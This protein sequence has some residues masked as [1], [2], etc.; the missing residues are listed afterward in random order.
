[1]NENM[2]T[3]MVSII[4]PVYKVPEQYLRQCIESCINQTMRK[5]EIILV[6]DGSPDDCGKI[7]DEYAKKDE[8]VRV[9]HKENGG[10][11]SARNAGFEAIQG[12]WHMYI[13]GDDWIDLDTCE[14]IFKVLNKY[15]DIDVV[16]WKCIQELGDKSIKGKWEWPCQDDEHVY[17][18]DECAELARNVLVYK[19]GIATA[20]CK[21]IR[22]EYAK[23]NGI[24]HDDRLKQGMEG[25]EFSL[26]TFYYAKHVLYINAYWNHYL[27]NPMSISKLGSEYNAKCITDCV[28]VMEEDIVSF[29]NK[30]VFEQTLYQRVV[31]ALIATGLSTYFHPSSKENLW[32][33]TR[34]YAKY[35]KDYPFYTK[36]IQKC[37]TEGMDKQ[38]RVVLLLLRFKLYF[39]LQI[40]SNVK[41]YY[42]KKG[43]FDY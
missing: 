27:F 2:N 30:D 5:I 26:R 20:Y 32:S 43:K 6:D 10:L 39:L 17:S 15:E 24:R 38:R 1:M 34:K 42:L 33:R 3:P 25:T 37:S 16:F 18:G 9:I 4:V 28:K 22:T 35:I 11:V 19:S 36:S 41:A 31:Y 13:D 14:S 21:L 7:C 23:K 12:E 40:V 29:R 8:R